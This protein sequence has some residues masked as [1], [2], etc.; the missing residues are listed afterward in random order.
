MSPAASPPPDTD[1]A[2]ASRAAVAARRA[3]AAVKA[4]VEAGE[5]SALDVAETAWR[6]PT[7]PEAT[8]RVTD[9][10]SSIPGIGRVRTQ[11]FLDELGISE[12]KRVGGL[13][14]RQRPRLRGFLRNRQPRPGN[15]LFVLSGPTAVGKSTLS[16]FIRESYPQVYFS[17]SATTRKPRPGEIDGVHYH[18]VSDAEFDRLIAADELLEWATVHNSNR[19]GTPREPV[20]RAI[21]EGRRVLLEIDI[22]GARSVRARVPEATLVFLAPPSW[23][24]LVQRLVGRGTED[25]AEQRR[26]LATARV[27]L[28]AQSEFDAL[29]VNREVVTAARE[30]VALMGV[31]RGIRSDA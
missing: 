20:F 11:R 13:G 15:A 1:R 18:F 4:A 17:V 25:P 5:R 27:E 6:E 10:L 3:R 16:E 9:L 21:A 2:A 30:V 19:Y 24:D 28:A 22:A 31:P 26:R 29:V 8:L 14:A 12:R 23:E 7:G